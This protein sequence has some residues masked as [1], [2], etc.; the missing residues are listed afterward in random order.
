MKQSRLLLLLSLFLTSIPLLAQT[1]EEAKAAAM[2]F[3]QQKKGNVSLKLSALKVLEG[4]QVS[5]RAQSGVRNSSTTGGDVYAFNAD[6]GGFALVCTGNGNTAIAGYSDKGK[7]DINNIPDA[8]KAWLTS[9]S[10]AMKNTKENYIQSPT[11]TG[12]AATPVAPFLKTQWGQGTPFNDKC[13]SNG[14]QTTLAGCVPVAL[15]QVLNYYHSEHKGT[16]QLYYSHQE[17]EMEYNIDYAK[18]SYDWNNM[19]NTYEDDKYNQTQADAVAKLILEC[20]IASRAQYDY[21]GT[22]ACIPFVALNK[23][24]GFDCMLVDRDIDDSPVLMTHNHYHVST[25]KWM[26]MIQNE[27][28]HGRPIIYSGSDLNHGNYLIKPIV[29]HCFVIDGIDAQNY[30][31]CNWGWYGYEDGYFDVALLNPTSLSYNYENGLR[32]RH[33]MIIGIQPRSGEYEETVYQT[34]A[35]ADRYEGDESIVKSRATNT[36][37][38][39]SSDLHFFTASNS[40]ETKKYNMKIVLV[41]EGTIKH[42]LNSFSATANGWPSYNHWMSCIKTPVSIENGTYELRLAYSPSDNTQKMKLCPMPKVLIPT[43]EIRNNGSSMI[44]HGLENEDINDTLTIVSIKP[45]TE[46]FA[47]TR[48]YLAVKGT[49]GLESTR[50]YLDFKNVET[51]KVY[52][53]Y[54]G[55]LSLC[56]FSHNYD[57][58]TSSNIYKFYPL[59]IDNGFT[60]PAGRYKVELKDCNDNKKVAIGGDLYIDVNERPNYPIMDGTDEA[61]IS[62]HSKYSWTEDKLRGYAIIDNTKEEDS[63]REAYPNF[64]FANK[65]KEPVTV[66][67]YMV[68][69]D[70]GEKM[71]A[72]INQTWIPDKAVPLFFYPYPVTGNY[73]FKC[74]YETPDGDRGGLQASYDNPDKWFYF[75]I[76]EGPLDTRRPQVELLSWTSSTN[77]NWNKIDLTMKST[78][79]KSIKITKGKAIYYDPEHEEVLVSDQDV[80]PDKTNYGEE[81]KLHFYHALTKGSKY[82]VRFQVCGYDNYYSFVTDDNNQIFEITTEKDGSTGISSIANEDNIFKNGESIRVYDLN[83]ILV[84]TLTASNNLWSDLQSQLP[85]GNYI[86]K[87]P[88]KTIKFGK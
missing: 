1:E 48:F 17:A 36:N 57:G 18:T 8:M 7:V 4:K 53:Q 77:N 44:L 65:I 27:L 3:L 79:T 35:P 61:S 54:N 64:N 86:L 55:G 69:K 30:V 60:M 42:T 80:D 33:E 39:T 23:Y 13:P 82:V 10:V 75:S 56:N 85:N 25:V 67:V 12:P 31:H 15:A 26:K 21:D 2:K 9:Y 78:S 50:V 34:T 47:G 28:E 58:Y 59:N 51:N 11:W 83:G 20:G 29:S 38:I 40:E 84:K 66:K 70:T 88:S 76:V 81:F 41:K 72:G 87:S 63:F 22:S 52:G 19:L 68:N 6:G 73:Y 14:M 74:V 16:G 32:C 49:G 43:V 24:Y 71:L 37:E 46:V 62:L 45:V 5:A